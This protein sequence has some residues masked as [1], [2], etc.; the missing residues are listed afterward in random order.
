MEAIQRPLQPR[1]GLDRL[2]VRPVDLRLPARPRL[3]PLLR[4][5][6]RLRPRPLDVAAHRVVAA[7]EAVIARQILIHPR[8]EQ[9][10]L[11]REPLVDHRLERVELRRHPPPAIHRLRSLLQIA[12]HRPP[13][14][15]DQ[16]A[17]LGVGKAL[18]LQRP[19]VHELLLIEHA[20]L[21]RRD[22]TTAVSVKKTADRKPTSTPQ[23]AAHA[24]GEARRPTG[25]SPPRPRTQTPNRGCRSTDRIRWPSTYIFEWI[26]AK[27]RGYDGRACLAS[28]SPR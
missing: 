12:L 16:P 25:S 18:A 13:I 26:R 11:P 6:L 14:A 21:P 22:D 20:A 8:R 3:E 19:H 24:A 7:V 10:R 5:R 1:R 23:Q 28:L 2:L 9:P 4:P 17:D 27:G 15:P